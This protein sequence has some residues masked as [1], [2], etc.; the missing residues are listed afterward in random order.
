MSHTLPTTEPNHL[1]HTSGFL[2]GDGGDHSHH[3][4]E[5]GGIRTVAG[6]PRQRLYGDADQAR[7]S[8][9]QDL[10][11][12]FGKL[13]LRVGNI[14]VDVFLRATNLLLLC[15]STL[16]SIIIF[17][18]CVVFVVSICFVG[19]VIGSWVFQTVR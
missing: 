19:I 6:R 8:A 11:L 15:A 2:P 10:V 18:L 14:L 3:D 7:F 17:G 12:E 4:H 16:S 9:L 1:R 5:A 13:L